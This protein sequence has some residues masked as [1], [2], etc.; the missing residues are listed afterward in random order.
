MNWKHL[1]W[2]IPLVILAT[3][4]IELRV[5][6]KLLDYTSINVM[7]RAA[8]MVEDARLAWEEK[9]LSENRVLVGVEFCYRI[10][11]ESICPKRNL[12]NFDIGGE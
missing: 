11:N 8:N 1:L 4:F 2:I 6:D 3:G 10:S 9:P 12:T 5:I 7:E